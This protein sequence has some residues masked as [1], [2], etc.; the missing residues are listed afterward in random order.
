MAQMDIRKR[1]QRQRLVDTFINAIFLYDD[2]LVI[3]FNY[4]NGTK[5]ISKEDWLR[6]DLSGHLRPLNLVN[7]NKKTAFI[8]RIK[9]VFLC[10]LRYVIDFRQ[11]KKCG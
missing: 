3:T 10:I 6:S 9:A 4:Q 2:K 8:H 5:T 11:F 1:E 7:T